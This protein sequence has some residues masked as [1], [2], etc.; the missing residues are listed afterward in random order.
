MKHR[1][2]EWPEERLPEGTGG[3]PYPVI[4]A[5]F[6]DVGR[7]RWI[8]DRRTRF[9]IGVIVALL[10]LEA[11]TLLVAIR[12]GGEPTAVP[13]AS[14]PPVAAGPTPAGSQ[15]PA[16]TERFRGPLRI[17][18]EGLG[19]DTDPPSP[20]GTY[21]DLSVSGAAATLSLQVF[22]TDDV[23]V[24]TG[25]SPPTADECRTQSSTQPLSIREHTIQPVRPGLGLCL[26]TFAGAYVAFLRVSQVESDAVDMDAVI[27]NPG[28]G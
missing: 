6:R 19:L 17:T 10:V 18:D 14:V 11:G 20:L 13:R 15:S 7:Q 24:W 12:L 21:R 23:S 4:D 25:D 16:G 26:T 22:T 9:L 3:G 8:D 5:S 28:P 1:G 2:P 27:W